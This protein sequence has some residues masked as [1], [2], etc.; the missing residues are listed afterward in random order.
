ALIDALERMDPEGRGVTTGEIIDAIRKP[1]DP[2]SEWLPEL[3]SAVEELCGKIDSRS[4]GYKLRHFAR[5]RFGGVMIDRAAGVSATNSV[6][7]VVRRVTPA[8]RSE[9]SPVSLE[10]STGDTGDTGDILGRSANIDLSA[11]FR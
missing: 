2:A 7:W 8:N 9:P 4:L 10:P 5:R 11:L 3:R 6:G 1:A